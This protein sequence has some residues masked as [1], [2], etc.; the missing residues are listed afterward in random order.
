MT[1]TGSCHC[2][3][4]RFSVEVAPESVTHCT[5]SYCSK[6]GALWAYYTPEQFTLLTPPENRGTYLW[7]S[8]TVQHYFCPTCGISTYGASPDYSTGEPDFEHPK[9]G[10]N[11][12]LFDDFDM[13]SVT[14]VE[15]DGKNLW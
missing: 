8:K 11:A 10:L 1:I 7:N 4:T 3:A 14:V 13:A 12:L 9:I 2:G 5:C 6:S 15:I